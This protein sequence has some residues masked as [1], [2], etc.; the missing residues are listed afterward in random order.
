MQIEGEAC[1]MRVF[2]GES[3]KSG[4]V[5]LYEAIVRAARDTGLSG[6]TV[7]RGVHGFGLTSHLRTTRILD[8]STDLPIVV[9]IVDT[10]EK[11]NA[12]LEPLNAMLEETGSGGLITLEAA[13]VIRHVPGKRD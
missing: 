10:R 6:A 11:V 5:A 1:L 12:F 4:G 7:L 13:H 2:I 3:D 9:E 8:L